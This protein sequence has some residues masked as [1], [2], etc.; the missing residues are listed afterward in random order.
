MVA[1]NAD[2]PPASSFAARVRS[3]VFW[4]WG[5]QVLA[6]LITWSATI[7][8]VRL[9]DPHDYGLFA[10]T[11]TVLTAL[12]FLNGYAFASSLIQSKEV[13]ERQVSQVFG[14][15][16]VSNGLIASAQFLTA[17]LVAAY[18]GQPVIAQMLRVQALVF[19][20]TPFIAL[21]SEL[22]ARKLDFR[23]QA[24]I[25]LTCASLG[26][27]VALTL[28]WKGY[29][30]WA[31]VWAPIVTFTCRAIG[32]SLAWGRLI[33]PVFD[34]RGAGK[35]LG[36]G[37]T[38]TLCQLC[39]I[40]QSQADIVI[41]GRHFTTHDLGIYSEALFFTLI[42]NGRFL[43][44]LNEVAYPA[45]AELKTNGLPLGPAFLST[46]RMIQMIAAPFY[47][48]LSLVAAPLVTVFFGPKW[49]EMIP[50]VAGLA[51]VMPI[52]SL[53]IAC[54]PPTNALG[55]PRIYLFTAASGALIMPLCYLFGVAYG[56]QGLVT[57]WHVAAPLLLAVTLAAA[58][59]VIGV[60]FIDLIKTLLP[61]AAACLAMAL[62][63][64]AL[65]MTVLAGLTPPVQL[66]ASA[67]A[68]AATYFATLRLIWPQVLSEVWLKLRQPK[69]G[70]ANT[71]PH[72]AETAFS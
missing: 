53:Q 58:L 36:Y 4:R 66:G 1:M 20:A 17:P 68:G 65:Q 15:L 59:P 63:V 29:G 60:R 34:F 6:Q 25:T 28:A 38:L 14:M 54:S 32:L 18:Y 67:A 69:G 9:L 12:N 22:L 45:Y 26:T 19:L 31:L 24:V 11:Q 64:R 40:V 23:R 46:I 13:S 8:I 72:E 35:M 61:V 56:L 39:W 5:G 43:P 3:A 50:I 52:M 57:A 16:L 27:A 30:V 10:M 41:A 42:F 44:P 70:A 37:M 71:P 2:N 7:I 21:P 62:V 33:R 55:R 51:A 47:I 48:G 49:L